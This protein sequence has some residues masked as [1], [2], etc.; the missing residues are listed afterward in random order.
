MTP[1]MAATSWGLES[2]AKFLLDDPRVDLDLRDS[3]GNNFV[4]YA[5]S[6]DWK[7]MV[8]LVARHPRINLQVPVRR[9]SEGQEYCDT[10]LVWAANQRN[11]SR[12]VG[13]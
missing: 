12:T 10:P 9:T 11:E 2:T 13:R 8:N 6:S 4:V 7:Q 5:F 3:E 1:L